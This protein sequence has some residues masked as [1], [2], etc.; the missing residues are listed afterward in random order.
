[1][2]NNHK[3]KSVFTVNDTLAAKGSALCLLLVCHLFIEHPNIGLRINGLSIAHFNADVS[4][5][6]V[7]MFVLLSG[8]GLCES[9]RK[10]TISFPKFFFNRL[11][12]IYVPYWFIGLIFV[13]L[14]IFFFDRT[15]NIV[16][17]D[18]IGLRILQNIF[19]IQ[20]FNG[21]NITWWYITLILMLYL[22]FPCLKFLIEK[23]GLPFLALTAIFLFVPLKFFSTIGFAWVVMMYLF[24]F[25][26]GVYISTYT[27]L[28]KLSTYYAD[29]KK[30]KLIF[31]LAIIGIIIWQREFGIFKPDG[32]GA[33][34]IIDG[35]FSLII[36]AFCFEYTFKINTIQNVFIFIGKHSYNIFLFHTFI[37]YYYFTEFIF[38]FKYPM[39]IFNIMLGLCLVLSVVIEWLK[40]VMGINRLS[41]FL[42]NLNFKDKYSFSKLKS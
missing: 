10:K 29:H 5:V 8:F 41:T 3:E 39:I 32:L 33:P 13:P 25:T 34:S 7:A 26:L 28:P 19:G 23:V 15:L 31:Y 22:L 18:N 2:N 40:T 4:K 6:C 9:I 27:V 35:P 38:Y 12:K 37:Y 14:G 17:R 36:I 30:K 11:V 1:M 20:G 24:P 21:Y 16:F 42:V